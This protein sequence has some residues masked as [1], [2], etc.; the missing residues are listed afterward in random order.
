L[1]WQVCEVASLTRPPLRTSVN[2]GLPQH[3]KP[4]GERRNFDGC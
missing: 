1:I 2:A 4:T 3:R